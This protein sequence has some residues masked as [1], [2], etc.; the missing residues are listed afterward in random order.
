M[1]LK[2]NNLD[3]QLEHA[4]SALDGCV[5]ALDE[6][7]V[8]IKDRRR[9]PKWRSLRAKCRTIS[10][11]IKAA[12]GVTALNEELKQRKAAKAAAAEAPPEKPEKKGKK[13][14]KASKEKSKKKGN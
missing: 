4:R 14:K 3:Q 10:R 1:P 9:D 6:R 11:R 8:A 7:G 13:D 5:K 12:E 2:K